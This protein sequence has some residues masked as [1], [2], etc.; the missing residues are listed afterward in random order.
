MPLPA[1]KVDKALV[2]KIGFERQDRR[3][4]R[5]L[6]LHNT[7]TL[8]LALI[9]SNRQASDE[10]L[11]RIVAHLA[12]APFASRPVRVTRW[13]REQSAQRD[14]ILTETKLPSVE[15]HL[16]KRVYIDQQWPLGT[17]ALTY[18]AD[19]HQA[20]QH[21]EAE[22]WTYRYYE[23]PMVGVLAPSHVRNVPNPQPFIYVAYNPRF[24]TIVTGYQTSGPEAIFTIG[25][26][27]IRKQ[28]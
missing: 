22:I 26:E 11:R 23:E 9:A 14:K 25:F 12:R 8:I 15:I 5:G 28:R 16:L 2:N 1:G 13:L 4:L 17:T 7:D 27:Q 10:E 19:L 24:G 20:V 21:P 3:H 18:L 6:T